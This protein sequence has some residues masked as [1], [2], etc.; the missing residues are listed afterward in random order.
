MFLYVSPLAC[1][2]RFSA[3]FSL[4]L[5]FAR[6]V[7]FSPVTRLRGAVRF[8]SKLLV[9]INWTACSVLAWIAHTCALDCMCSNFFFFSS[10]AARRVSIS[11]QVQEC[12]GP[13]QHRTLKIMK[14]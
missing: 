1:I 11:W 4:P 14:Y 12:I 3:P 9:K 13:D 5:M 8:F 10:L 6:H 2:H 7:V